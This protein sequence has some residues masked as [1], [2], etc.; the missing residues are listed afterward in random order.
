M[1]VPWKYAYSNVHGTRIAWRVRVAASP[2]KPCC[3]SSNEWYPPV[4]EDDDLRICVHNGRYTSELHW[5]DGKMEIGGAPL[6]SKGMVSGWADHVSTAFP[7][8]HTAALSITCLLYTSP[9]PRD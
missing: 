4:L 9:S 7:P 6:R 8:P 1:G 5:R 2:H 3:I